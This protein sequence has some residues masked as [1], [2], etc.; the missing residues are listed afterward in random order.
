MET[1]S[2]RLKD[3]DLERQTIHI[4]NVKTGSRNQLIG[5]GAGGRNR[6]ADT[7]IFSPLLYRLSYPGFLFLAD[8]RLD[9]GEVSEIITKALPCQLDSPV[10]AFHLKSLIFLI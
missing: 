3:I 9:A 5:N 7:R 2:I 1:L 4:P 10:H 6:T 8:I